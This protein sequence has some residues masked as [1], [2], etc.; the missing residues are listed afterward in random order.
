M[1]TEEEKKKVKENTRVKG[2]GDAE[3]TL[4]LDGEEI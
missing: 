3:I 4:K 1:A 2:F